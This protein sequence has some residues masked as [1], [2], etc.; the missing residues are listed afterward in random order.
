M[1]KKALLRALSKFS[2]FKPFVVALAYSPWL[3][4]LYYFI[5]FYITQLPQGDKDFI[6]S[7]IE[8]FGTAYSLFLALV[9]VNVWGQFDIVER[10]F[11][12][13]VDALATMYQ[14]INRIPEA[15]EQD[16]VIIKD[17]KKNIKLK[18]IT[19]IHHVI[20]NYDKE[21]DIPQQRRNGE[22]ILEMIGNQ[23]SEL[24]PKVNIKDFFISEAFESLNEAMDVRGDRIAHSKQRIPQ[25]VWF[26]AVISSIVW[27]IPFLGLEI[28]SLLVTFTL[29]GG[30]TFVIVI[31]LV[32][33][34][35]LDNPF[36]GTWKI[37]L[38]SWEGFLEV[39]EPK[40]QFIFV[41]NIKH[42]LFEQVGILLGSKT[43]KLKSLSSS[44]FFGLGWREFRK[45]IEKKYP[46]SDYK[47]KSKVFY[48]DEFND[49]GFNFPPRGSSF[50]L[51]I[52]KDGD[53][54]SVLMSA[55]EIS[56]C[57]D[58]IK[59]EEMFRRRVREQIEWF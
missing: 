28:V 46:D 41:F 50:P 1:N 7:F 36:E 51:V 59:F 39:L 4:I 37:E 53:R 3:I 32:I 57:T 26:V 12:R 43:C 55:G 58:L 23:I 33:I 40:F 27:M 35:D 6:E 56:E 17:F 15:N 52:L 18:I 9:L 48:L 21:H 22:I 49:Q 19:Y 44:G 31:V 11:D 10:E 29:V 2:A 14:V 34:Y 20:Q 30:V 45:R 8:W 47:I 25:T 13:E 24:V 38:E 42:T 16:A 54:L 5:Q